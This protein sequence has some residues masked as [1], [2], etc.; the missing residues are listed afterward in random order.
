MQRAKML[1]RC[2][3]FLD[4]LAHAQLSE[5]SPR[6]VRRAMQDLLDCTDALGVKAELRIQR[7][8][9][10]QRITDKLLLFRRHQSSITLRISAPGQPAGASTE[11]YFH[12]P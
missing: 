9:I 11:I 1:D 5:C 8:K 7:T 12:L 2:G 4:P 3:R 6:L 10:N